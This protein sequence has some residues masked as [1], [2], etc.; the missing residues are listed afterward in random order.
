M[1]SLSFR[2]L[3]TRDWRTK[4]SSE[5]GTDSILSSTAL[6][7]EVVI[8]AVDG[9]GPSLVAL[10]WVLERAQTVPLTLQ[11]TSVVETGWAPSGD[12][13]DNFQ[14]AYEHA[15]IEAG[16]LVE[17]RLPTL[18]TT[19]YLRRGAPV[20]ELVRASGSADLLVLGSK[21]TNTLT[22]HVFGT[23]VLRV[24]AHAH[25]PVVAV[26][27]HWRPTGSSAVASPGA[28]GASG[29]SAERES[30]VV[31]GLGDDPSSDSA[32]DF[33]AREA[34]R[35]RVP[36]D[37]VHAWNIPATLSMDYDAII[38]FEELQ[39]VHEGIL[40]EAARRI[41]S[42]YP[43][44]HINEILEQGSAAKALVDASRSAALTVVG[45][46]GRGAF[47]GLVLGSVS[48]DL[49]INLP[50]AVAVV[51]TNDTSDAEAD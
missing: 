49:L 13:Q 33:A 50:C 23:L 22:G 24:A 3:S 43:R 35:R 38:P 32:V 15:L 19:S 47:A 48:H 37:I 45:T 25:C 5:S 11:L 44:L 39:S 51:P 12:T 18:K 27:A 7:A 26:P 31:V 9:T 29:A 40:S 6:T 17:E 4:M 36:L 34:D 8:V 10:D 20:E 16:R 28:S 46:H 42:V 30:Q 2:T 41:R 21:K 14:P 1:L